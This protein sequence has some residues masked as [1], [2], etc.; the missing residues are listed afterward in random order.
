MIRL[1][2]H[3]MM[4]LLLEVQEMFQRDE[5]VFHFYP[6]ETFGEALSWWIRSRPEASQTLAKIVG[7]HPNTLSTWCAPRGQKK[8][9]VEVVLRL[10]DATNDVF[11]IQWL[12]ARVGL[13]VPKWLQSEGQNAG[14]RTS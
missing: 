10:V 11:L 3:K 13:A 12:A 14:T 4:I 8:I 1:L 9:P 7:V 6:G 2:S 5:Q